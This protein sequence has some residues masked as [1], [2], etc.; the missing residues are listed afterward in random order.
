M[1]LDAIVFTFENFKRLRVSLFVLVGLPSA[2]HQD[3]NTLRLPGF[4]FLPY[5]TI[6]I[7]LYL[8]IIYIYI[9]LSFRFKSTL[10]IYSLYYSYTFDSR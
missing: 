4:T 8:H 2:S 5:V 9:C 7:R 10:L 3:Q 6:R 1:A